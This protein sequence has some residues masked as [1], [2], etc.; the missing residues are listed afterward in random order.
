M[1][2]FDI[3]G[4]VIDGTGSD[5]SNVAIGE[6]TATTLQE[7]NN[8]FEVY[9]F[10]DGYY[11]NGNGVETVNANY[12]VSEFIPYDAGVE[13]RFEFTVKNL[14]PILFCYDSEKNFISSVEGGYSVIGESQ[15]LTS[16]E[17]TA[18][19]RFSLNKGYVSNGSIS[20]YLKQYVTY[21]ELVDTAQKRWK[22]NEEDAVRDR[23]L[24][25]IDALI[26][27]YTKW[28]GKSLVTDGNSLVQSTNW[29][30]YLA[31]FL[32][33]NHT[34]CGNSGSMITVTTD[35][36]D[37]IKANIA[38]NY[39]DACDL[40]ILQGD[41]NGS[42]D[43]DVSDQMDDADN[44]KT[45]WTARMNYLIRCIKAKYHNVVIVMMPDSVRFDNGGQ[46]YDLEK[47]TVSYTAMKSLAEYNRL[48]FF[49]FDHSTPYNP[50]H[51]DNWYSRMGDTGDKQDYVHPGGYYR[52]AKGYALAHFVAGLVFDPNAPNTATEGWEDTV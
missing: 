13:I 38:D 11:L 39:P 30:D 43:G 31:S 12:A 50:N 47:N 52:N 29:G 42:M 51:D 19:I 22:K 4:N 35:T 10:T 5:A 33:M 15:T 24:S 9:S 46:S 45:T 18:Y 27:N 21:Y 41:T 32:G 49:D 17:N 8:L 25:G 40:V 16:P 48:A 44:P 20:A 6:I 34:N 23:R 1:S 37:T 7:E 36:T 26:Y 14:K 28:N 2:V 3:N